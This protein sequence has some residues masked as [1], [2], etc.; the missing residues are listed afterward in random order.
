LKYNILLF[1][2]FLISVS[3]QQEKGND[4]I[5]AKS[6]NKT[7]DVAQNNK[8]TTKDNLSSQPTPKKSEPSQKT[9]G[10]STLTLAYK[11][12]NLGYLAN[13]YY[14][15]KAY[16]NV[17]SAYNDFADKPS[18]D[19]QHDVIKIPQLSHLS[20][21]KTWPKLL[22]IADELDKIIQVQNIHLTQERKLWDLPRDPENRNFRP[23]LPTQKEVILGAAKLM[24]ESIAG[25][26]RQENPPKK[27]IG[28]F[29]QVAENLESIAQGKIDENSYALDMVHQRLAHGLANCI[30][31]AKEEYCD[32]YKN[33]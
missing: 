25:L 32:N 16:R 6:N 7:T 4:K 9:A 10:G 31:W 23:V 27:A 17:L 5:S 33:Y 15:N 22:L 12:A 24:Y 18:I 2:F 26:E 14:G 28:Q 1:I 8:S 30:L 11:G 20:K 3:C 21:D 13:K 19:K 29:K